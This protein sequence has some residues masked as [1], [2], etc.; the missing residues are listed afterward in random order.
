MEKKLS[1]LQLGEKAIVK[2]IPQSLLSHV[3][4]MGLRVNKPVELSSKQPMN[5]PVTFI[6]GTSSISLGRTLADQ[7]TIEVK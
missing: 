2:H 4:G 7:I 5:G 6:I 1:D 3:S